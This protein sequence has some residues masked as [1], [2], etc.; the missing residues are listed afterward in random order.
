MRAC[1]KDGIEKKRKFSEVLSFPRVPCDKAKKWC[2]KDKPIIFNDGAI[3]HET[4]AGKETLGFLYISLKAQIN[5]EKY[6]IHLL[7]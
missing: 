5:S 1:Q 6:M 3:I 2:F 7:P 4:H